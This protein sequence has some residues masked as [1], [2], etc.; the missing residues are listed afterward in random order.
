MQTNKNL[1]PIITEFFLRG[2]K[3]N[4]SLV[5]LPQ[6]Y[7]KVPQTIRLNTTNYFYEKTGTKKNSNKLHQIARLILVLKVL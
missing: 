7:F 4:V 1:S 2:R 3:P 5:F 6:F